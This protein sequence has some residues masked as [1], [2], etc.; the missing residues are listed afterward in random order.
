MMRLLFFFTAAISLLLIILISFFWLP[1]L[2]F[3]V[4]VGP[5]VLIGCYDSFLSSSNIKRIYP[6]LGNFRFFFEF[7]RPEIQQYFIHTNQ[8][9][10]PFDRE[11]RT[12]VYQRA[13]DVAAILPFGTEQSL[14]TNGYEYAYHAF[15]ASPVSSESARIVVGGPDCHK[16]YSAS[17]LNI[18]AMSFG[19]ISWNAVRALNRAAK[20]ENFAHNTGEG[21]I[22]SY[23]LEYGGDLIWQIGTG[24]FGCR[25][26][27]GKFDFEEFQNKMAFDAVKMVELKLSQ[28]AK[29]SNGGILPA[30]KIT[31]EIAEIRG[32]EMGKDCIS[33]SSHS[34]F[35]DPKGLLEFIAYLRDLSGGKPV[36]FKLCIGRKK[37]FLSICKAMLETGITPDFISVDGA[38][39]G[40][41]A[42]PIELS[43]FYGAPIN[44]ALAF[45][46]SSLVG[47]NLRDKITIIAAGKIIT[48]FDIL[49][50]I[51]LGA[52]ICYSARGMMFAL[53]CVMSLR[54]HK[55]TCPTGI[56]TQNPHRVQGLVVKD[57]YLRVANFHRNTLNSFLDNLGIIGVEHP[58][59]LKPA[60]I[61]RRMEKDNSKN[62]EE[63]YSYLEPGALLNGT[64]HP[65][66][67]QDWAIANA[68]SFN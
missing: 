63:I 34:E 27:E 24:Y 45:V 9:G 46:H 10:K 62:F 3:L 20:Q 1:V 42:S 4:I 35:S 38:E 30:A 33:P 8:N 21:G 5:Y 23:H 7:V 26:K 31:P 13:K 16:P 37:D 55:N 40:T 56:T 54:C 25:T 15:R 39:G 44:E 49:T 52:D 14:L 43:N 2:Y 65:A 68:N 53:G 6:F 36:G 41:G 32:I 60:H 12:I 17:R 29:P 66:F 11:T 22:S 64:I 67:H 59:E 47:V 57:K 61:Y 58:D 48:G 50:K 51:A 19:A 28:G 18:G